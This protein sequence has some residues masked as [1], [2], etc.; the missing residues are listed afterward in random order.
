MNT[1]LQSDRLCL[2]L[3]RQPGENGPA[4]PPGGS[5]RGPESVIDAQLL[6]YSR[7]P[8]PTKREVLE[9]GRRVQAWQRREGELA[10]MA[11]KGQD[12]ES[13]KREKS[14]QKLARSGLRARERLVSGNMRLAVTVAKKYQ[15]RGLPIEDLIQEGALGLSKAAEGF[16]PTRGYTFSTYAYWWIRQ[17]VVLA[18]HQKAELIRVPAGTAD[19]LVRLRRLLST[20]EN[21]LSS[22]EI[23][24]LL[25]LKSERDLAR[26]NLAAQSRSCRSLSAPLSSTAD[27]HCL[28]DTLACPK[29][30]NETL[31]SMLEH[32]LRQERLQR[33]FEHMNTQQAEGVRMLLLG[34]D[35][36]A[37]SRQ[38]NV[39]AS[40]SN[41]VLRDAVDRLTAMVARE[42]AGLPAVGPA[43][44]GLPAVHQLNWL[45]PQLA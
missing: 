43:E 10:K 27:E 24:C 37:I 4:R 9:L 6:A 14:Y 23:V 17:A 34:L 41:E 29:Q 35:R 7:A 12:V 33:L 2:P 44:K 31:D 21:T 25:G 18:L 22:Q 36:R 42:D 38:L 11:E 26:I 20:Q 19:V 13:L 32:M 28:E 8:I 16:D 45:D 30:N 1:P 5:R 40:R 3:M 39:S 15:G